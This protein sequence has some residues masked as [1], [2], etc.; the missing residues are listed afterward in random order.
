MLLSLYCVLIYTEAVVRQIL[1]KDGINKAL[2]DLILE[3]N[4]DYSSSEIFS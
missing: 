2:L 3:A 1:S 4:D